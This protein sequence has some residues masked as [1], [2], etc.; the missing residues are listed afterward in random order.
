MT[1]PITPAPL[2][3]AL[4]ADYPEVEVAMRFRGTGGQLIKRKDQDGV[5]IREEDIVFAD[6]ELFEVFDI[7]LV[8][9]DAKNSTYRTQ[10]HHHF[11]ANG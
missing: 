8:E 10:Y 11:Q 3:E 2:A 6:Q 7:P 4:V 9:G 1:G 5:N